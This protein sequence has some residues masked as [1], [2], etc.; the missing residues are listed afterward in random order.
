MKTTIYSSIACLLLAFFITNGYS[1]G[2]R[3]G[4][5]A[6]GFSLKDARNDKMVSLNNYSKEK[7][8]IV[9][10][11]CNHCPYAKKYEKRIIALNKTFSSKGFPVVAISPNDPSIVP[12]DS[13][14]EMKKLAKS[15]KYSFP[16]LFDETQDIAKTYG[17]TKTPHVFL[18]SNSNG[19]FTV[20]FIG[21]IDDNA[22]DETAV[23]TKYVEQAIGEI[24]VGKPV[25]T[26]EAKAIGCSIK[27]KKANG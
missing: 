9:I 12:E 11:T 19:T 27:W 18:L 25:T 4:D 2:F 21:A 3:P 17:A 26:Q 10:F 22:N 15:K 5:V 23:T 20:E 14:T 24:M 13:F 1:Q 6:T 7:G 8:V 16:Y